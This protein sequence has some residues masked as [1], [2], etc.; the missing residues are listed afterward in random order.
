MPNRLLRVLAAAS[1]IASSPGLS[2]P[3]PSVGDEASLR[4]IDEH[5]RAL[6][7]SRDVA[8]MAALAD[9]DLHINAPTNK[10]L[11]GQQLVGMMKSGAV[12][13]ENFVRVPE[14]V[15]ISG[16]IG[17][18]MGHEHFTAT[19]DSDSGKM[20]GARSLDRR[21]TNIYRWKDGRWRFLARHANV[22]PAEAIQTPR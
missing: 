17:I 2:Q 4:S 15:T 21:Y 8:G 7:A 13:A 9:P 11:T 6:I 12:A 16:D 10:I 5:Q 20:F 1:V 14:S 18:V 19:A 3:A 22:V